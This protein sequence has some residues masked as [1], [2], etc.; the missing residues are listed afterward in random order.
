LKKVF[1]ALG[2]I[3]V[4]AALGT[5]VA[6]YPA[7]EPPPPEDTGP[8]PAP[9]DKWA[10]EIVSG[11]NRAH[12]GAPSEVFDNAR[13]DLVKAFVKMGFQKKNMEQFSANFDPDARPT[14][15]ISAAE[16]L[17]DAAHRAPAGCLIYCTS[18]GTPEGIIVG[19]GLATPPMMAKLVSNAC[20]DRPA[21]VVMSA[22]YSGQFVLPLKAANRIIMT[23]AR[24][25]R[26]SF[27][28]GEADHYTF[29][30]DCFLRAIP[31]A[32][33]FAGLGQEVQN[34]VSVREEQMKASP[35]SEPQVSVGPNV[36]FT[37]RWKT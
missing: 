19:N 30:D 5:A 18:H 10:V 21:V 37:L 11:D 25:D 28:C 2:V 24:P 27:G 22:C 9:F 14:D 7:P 31:L 36:A 20:G 13:Q 6:L 32:S 17:K 35:P 26:T 29:F 12:S 8:P 1:V 15:I 34:C 16:L 23:A 4:A 33:D 3:V